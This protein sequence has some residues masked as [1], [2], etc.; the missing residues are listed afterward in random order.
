M[1]PSGVVAPHGTERKA[2]EPKSGAKPAVESS[3]AATSLARQLCGLLPGVQD[4]LFPRQA[5]N[6]VWALGR[7]HSLGLPVVEEPRTG[8]RTSK[9]SALSSAE[10]SGGSGPDAG[11]LTSIGVAATAAG[12]DSLAA[13]SERLSAC[14]MAPRFTKVRASLYPW[15][16]CTTAQCVCE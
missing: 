11:A 14:R 15:H 8:K 7:L 16:F 5:A 13:V 2:L 6:C 3:E 10:S 9:A 4:R 1:V 12:R